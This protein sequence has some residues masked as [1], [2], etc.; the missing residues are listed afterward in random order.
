MVIFHFISESSLIVRE[1][2]S[3]NAKLH[4]YTGVL[5]LRDSMIVLSNSLVFRSD[6]SNGTEIKNRRWGEL[7]VSKTLFAAT[8]R[9]EITNETTITNVGTLDKLARRWNTTTD[10][11]Y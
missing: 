3:I 7:T 10:R 5:S 6:I 9:S 4:K 11:A 2:N 1:L 8:I